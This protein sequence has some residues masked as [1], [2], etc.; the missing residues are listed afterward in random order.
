MGRAILI[1]LAAL[2]AT[3]AHAA[4]AVH[5]AAEP[6]CYVAEVIVVAH[7]DRDEVIDRVATTGIWQFRR[8]PSS[9]GDRCIPDDSGAFGALQQLLAHRL[10]STSVNPGAHRSFVDLRDTSIAAVRRTISSIAAGA[11]NRRGT[12]E[13]LELLVPPQSARL[14]GTPVELGALAHDATQAAA[15]AADNRKLRDAPFR[16]AC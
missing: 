12:F 5:I 11:E 15:C 6:A 8:S 2:H 16:W 7:D 10:D 14:A 9:R 3:P 1:L 13:R 4:P